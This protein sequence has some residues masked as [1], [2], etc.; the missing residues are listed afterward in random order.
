MFVSSETASSTLREQDVELV[1]RCLAGQRAAQRELFAREKK[2]VHAT[3]YRISGTNQ[4]V[5]DMLQEVFITVFR[6]LHQ[7]R[8]EARLSTWIDRCAVHVAYQ[9][10]RTRRRARLEVVSESL[11]SDA[12][13]AEDQ[14]LT[15][16]ATRRLYQVLDQL[17]PKQR[18][19]YALHVLEGRSMAEVAELTEASVVATKVRVFRAR[20]EVARRARNDALLR[21]F[22]VAGEA[23]DVV[24]ETES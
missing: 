12:A 15:R 18:V 14:M 13:S 24:E 1:Q 6:S 16:E 3:L 19:A 9:H 5:D 22:M 23:V 7:F 10:L 17:E 20:R 4:G 2:R 21:D 11:A 8:G